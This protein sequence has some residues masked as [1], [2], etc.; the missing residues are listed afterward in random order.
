ML[1]SIAPDLHSRYPEIKIYLIGG[2]SESCA[3]SRMAESINKSFGKRIIFTPGG[4][5]TPAS[6]VDESTLFVG[7]SRAAL[8]GMKVGAP[9]I[10]LGDEGYLGLLEGKNLS[11]AIKTNLTCRGCD[12]TPSIK[13]LLCEICSALDFDDIEWQRHS[14]FSKTVVEKFFSA[15]KMAQNTLIFYKRILKRHQNAHFLS[16]N[17]TKKSRKIAICGYFGR[18]NLGDEMILSQILKA[19]KKANPKER[20]LR[21][22][23]IK[24]HSPKAIIKALSG[25]D[26][27]IFGGGSLLQNATSDA[28]F[29]FYLSVI[30]L[31]S[32]LCQSKV[33]LSNGIGPINGGKIKRMILDFL[34]ASATNTFDIITV[35]DESSRK[36]LERLLP[37]RKIRLLN[38]PAWTHFASKQIENHSDFDANINRWLICE[39][40]FVFIPS[41]RALELAKITPKDVAR[42]LKTVAEQCSLAP[43]IAIIS[44]EDLPIAREIEKEFC[45][46]GK[47]KGEFL[48]GDKTETALVK[49]CE[50]APQSKGKII[51]IQAAFSPRELENELKAAK[52]CICQRYH[53]AFFTLEKGVPL[54]CISKDPKMTALS[55]EFDL[56]I[57]K[58][59]EV[60]KHPDDLLTACELALSNKS[61]SGKENQEIIF[62]KS[63][64]SS[65]VLQKIMKFFI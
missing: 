40:K 16:A 55:R 32:L 21:V 45:Q 33:M 41:T 20:N 28:S 62:K 7:V 51:K 48:K 25:A 19:I 2:G 57:H 24:T 35:R 36:Y 27:F 46:E 61:H 1:L 14:R 8:E 39:D 60:F 54:V 13:A 10:L 18:G 44:K 65:V 15:D 22:N 53:G 11:A 52:L 26:V 6:F 9:T 63:R 37:K 5:E 30:F 59:E 4:V 42:A 3:I 29:I 12:C 58:D 31:A 47:I 49:K 34:L 38:D 43:V 17:D 50:R 23:I 64:Q 56:I